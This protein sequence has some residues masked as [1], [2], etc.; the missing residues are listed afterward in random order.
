MRHSAPY[1][2]TG[3]YRSSALRR[4]FAASQYAT[5][6]SGFSL[7]EA[8]V[9]LL[10]LS[11]ALLGLAFL[12]AQGMQFNTSAY[13]RS[14]A[15]MLSSDIIDRMRLNAANAAA[16]DTGSFSP[17]PADCDFTSAPDPDN[18]RDCWYRR[19]QEALPGGDGSITVNGTLVTVTVSWNERPGAQRDADFDPDTL[20]AADLVQDMSVSV[21][22]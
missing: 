22:L 21:M 1:R 20:A 16:Y 6:Q 14:Q 12:Q 2:Q 3:K 19:L 13:A 18:D 11:V 7:L 5:R 4:T 15:S 10:I 8:L 9:T 17:T